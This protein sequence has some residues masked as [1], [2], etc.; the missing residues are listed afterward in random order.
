MNLVT[1]LPLDVQKVAGKYRKENRFLFWLVNNY[2]V[3]E[4]LSPQS[5]NNIVKFNNLLDINNLKS[6]LILKPY[7]SSLDT[8]QDMYF[9]PNYSDI[10]DLNIIKQFML[11][12][13]PIAFVD[14]DIDNNEYNQQLS[15]INDK[16]RYLEL[17]LQ[18]VGAFWEE[19]KQ[20]KPGQFYLVEVK[21]SI[22]LD[23]R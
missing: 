21:N 20:I 2:F 22:K 8:E 7:A 5:D 12:I 11:L 13:L 15:D 3:N 6:K 17:P 1:S 16:L 10:I 4:D 18:I 23:I 19:Q 9:K 14:G